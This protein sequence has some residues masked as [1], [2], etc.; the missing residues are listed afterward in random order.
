MISSYHRALLLLL[1]CAEYYTSETKEH[2]EVSIFPF[3]ASCR[4]LRLTSPPEAEKRLKAHK[5]RSIASFNHNPSPVSAR[6]E[7]NLR[8]GSACRRILYKGPF[9]PGKL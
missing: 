8:E 1:T 7:P 3:H 9:V 2:A 6:K 5:P 4:W